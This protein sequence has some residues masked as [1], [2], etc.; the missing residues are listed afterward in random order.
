MKYLKK[1]KLFES[2]NED[3]ITELDDILLELKDLGYFVDI[4]EM[5]G[6]GV[7]NPAKIRVYIGGIADSNF[8]YDDVKEVF[9]RMTDYMESENFTILNM[10]YSTPEDPNSHFMVNL[11]DY[12]NG[13]LS[14]SFFHDA[15]DK[16]GFTLD[17]PLIEKYY[18]FNHLQISFT[19]KS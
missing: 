16:V 15:R 13:V 2:F 7:L 3:I 5:K 8:A 10:F 6:S 19:P 12:K 4:T 1:Y 18:I 9:E 17:S 11:E 14:S